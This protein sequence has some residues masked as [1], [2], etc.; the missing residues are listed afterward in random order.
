M[1]SSTCTCKF[2]DRI[3]DL[4]KIGF[5]F[6]TALLAADA[7]IFQTTI[8]GDIALTELVKLAVLAV[9]M[10]L[11]VTLL[12]NDRNYQ[13]FQKAAATRAN[14]LERNLNLELTEVITQRHQA[15]NVRLLVMA[16]YMAFT[17]GVFVLGLVTISSLL[18][19]VGLAIVFVVANS[20]IISLNR[21][22][23]PKNPFVLLDYPYG[24]IDWSLDR[25]QFCRGGQVGITATNLSDGE[26]VFLKDTLMYQIKREGEESA[27]KEE[28]AKKTFKIDKGDSYTWQWPIPKDLE[29]GI[30]RV[31]RI[32]L[33][34]ENRPLP[35]ELK[36]T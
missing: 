27:V 14:I 9:N 18:I 17:V 30:F 15:K 25:L 16:I 19:R 8:L 20:F 3:L 34:K 31:Y 10:L 12:V 22:F 33:N 21:P 36:G 28:K 26:I 13:V 23:A 2:D 6:L 11:I 24:R 5:T 29:P 7:I 35:L 4:R 1:T 32:T